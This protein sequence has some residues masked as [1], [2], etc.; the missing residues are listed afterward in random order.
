MKLL[1]ALNIQLVQQQF[2]KSSIFYLSIGQNSKDALTNNLF[3]KFLEEIDSIIFEY[4][5]VDNSEEYKNISLFNEDLIYVNPHIQNHVGEL[6][7]LIKPFETTASFIKNDLLL[8]LMNIFKNDFEIDKNTLVQLIN[9]YLNRV[10]F[11]YLFAENNISINDFNL[12]SFKKK[13]TISHVSVEQAFIEFEDKFLISHLSTIDETL[14]NLPDKV[15]VFEIPTVSDVQEVLDVFTSL[16]AYLMENT[17]RLHPKSFEQN[18]FYSLQ[19]AMESFVEL[20]E[21][22]EYLNENDIPR[23]TIPYSINALDAIDVEELSIAVVT[24]YN[25]IV[26]ILGFLYDLKDVDFLDMYLQQTNSKSLYT[27]FKLFNFDL[28]NS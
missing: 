5:D 28:S 19:N 8:V 14:S 11:Y 2:D 24:R 27:R 21:V 18:L 9:T 26:S 10:T 16:L 1:E 23:D 22:K 3:E 20:I 25:D 13:F 15:D 12:N 7:I 6:N 17:D 4:N